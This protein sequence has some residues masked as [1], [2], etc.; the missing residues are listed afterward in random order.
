MIAWLASQPNDLEAPA[1]AFQPVISDVLA[2]LATCDGCLLARMS[3]S[4]ATC[5]GLFAMALRT[6][7]VPDPQDSDQ[8]LPP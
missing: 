2:M 1:R 4:G 7:M 8:P 6:A 3:G 5:F